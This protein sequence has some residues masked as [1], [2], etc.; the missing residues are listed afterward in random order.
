L[1]FEWGAIRKAGEL[2]R[3]SLFRGL[4]AA[5]A[6]PVIGAPVISRPLPQDWL[7]E[8]YVRPVMLR[9]GRQIEADLLLCQVDYPRSLHIG[10]TWQAYLG[11][12]EPDFSRQ[13]IA[14]TND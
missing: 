12:S 1:K 14:L 3:R 7:F 13:Y 2:T 5:I 10:P 9:V 8:A 11:E 6:A 4:F